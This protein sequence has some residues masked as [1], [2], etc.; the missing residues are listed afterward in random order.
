VLR[1]AR[2]S[3]RGNNNAPVGAVAGFDTALGYR[4]I[5][6]DGRLYQAHRLIWL[7][8]FGVWPAAEIDHR[9][10]NGFDNRLSNLRSATSSLN[11]QNRHAARSDSHTGVL[12]VTFDKRRSRYFARI[13]IDGRQR[14]L[15][16]YDSPGA[17]HLAYINAKR[18]NHPGCTI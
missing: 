11:K 6:V 8:V 15:G 18:A 7:H 12:G 17:A 3:G 16:S 5:R 4:A 2:R 9:N 14:F 1:W 13:R 10:G